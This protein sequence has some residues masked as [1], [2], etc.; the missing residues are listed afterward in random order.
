[1][2]RAVDEL[3]SLDRGAALIKDPSGP[4]RSETVSRVSRGFRPKR[5]ASRMP[6]KLSKVRG[7]LQMRLKERRKHMCRM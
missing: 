3:G 1:M 7:R 4:D 5:M 6:G 2:D